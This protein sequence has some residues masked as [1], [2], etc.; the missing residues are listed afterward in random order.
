M[1][2]GFKRLS[3]NLELWHRWRWCKYSAVCRHHADW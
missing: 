1:S 3:W 2:L